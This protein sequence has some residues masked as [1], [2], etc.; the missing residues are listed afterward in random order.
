MPANNARVYF[1]GQ[2]VLARRGLGEERC[3]ATGYA[4]I[5]VDEAHHLVG[6]SSLRS[7]LAELGAAKSSLLFLGDASQATPCTEYDS[8]GHPTALSTASVF[9]I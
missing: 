1:P 5:V 9:K 4:R 2:P 8:A 6:D 3:D 7:E